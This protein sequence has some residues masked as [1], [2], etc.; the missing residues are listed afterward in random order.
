ML[1]F[2]NPSWN[3]QPGNDHLESTTEHR[4]GIV[5]LL[6]SASRN[7]K[8]SCQN[9]DLN[10]IKPLNQICLAVME[11][12][13]ICAIQVT[14]VQCTAAEHLNSASVPEGLI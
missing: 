3:S 4:S 14:A 11:I 2:C 10:L 12:F 6:L 13:F 1:S 8:H 7:L 5:H 9:S